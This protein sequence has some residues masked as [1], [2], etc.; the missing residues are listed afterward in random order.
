MAFR[1]ILS[2]LGK[3]LDHEKVFAF[4]VDAFT[5]GKGPDQEDQPF[6]VQ[7]EL[8]AI[9]Q[10]HLRDQDFTSAKRVLEFLSGP[11]AKHL[12]SPTFERGVAQLRARLDVATGNFDAALAFHRSKL[13]FSNSY[14]IH[15][16]IAR[17]L[18]LKGA[19]AEAIEAL[20]EVYAQSPAT[21]A[22]AEKHSDFAA[23]VASPEYRE[24]FPSRE[25]P[26]DEALLSAYKSASSDP[27]RVYERLEKHRAN[28][29]DLLDLLGV[30]VYC[31]DTICSDLDEH[32]TANMDEYGGRKKS[33]ADFFKLKERLHSDLAQERKRSG[34]SDVPFWKYK[35]W[36]PKK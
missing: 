1:E 36:S 15:L 20:A 18:A 35:G 16:D 27:Y 4:I 8:T 11:V 34:R 28:T 23:L 7:S 26:S 29:K 6:L 5:G 32:G 31:I 22:S 21:R 3:T 10:R 14:D 30:Q 13:E 24:R 17:V 12:R 2:A 25:L 9:F 19:T 33:V